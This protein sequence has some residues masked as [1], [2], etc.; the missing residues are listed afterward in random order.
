MSE[1]ILLARSSDDVPN[2]DMIAGAWLAEF[3]SYET[4]KAYKRDLAAWFQFCDV[5][6]VDPVNDAQRSHVALYARHN[7][8]TGLS[9]A[10]RAR[11]I[12]TLR[13]WYGWMQ[14]EHWIDRANPAARIKS[15]HVSVV[16]PGTALSRGQMHQL[17]AHAAEQDNPHA[18]ALVMLG[19]VNGL[20]IAEICG[21]A[22]DDI[23]RERFHHVARVLRKGGAYHVVGLQP[24]VMD[25]VSLAVDDRTAG[26][27]LLNTIG[28]RLR[29]S[30]ARTLL[31]HLCEDAGVTR[32]TP[33]DLRR[34]CAT[35]LLADGVPIADVAKHLNHASVSTTM[36]YDHRRRSL[37]NDLGSRLIQYTA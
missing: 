2:R 27:L 1:T 7:D 19:Y 13:G 18:Y 36:R 21:I 28:D 34:T 6:Q 24:R 37:D 16:R 33:H 25:A 11:R 15:P 31:D 12:G 29:P 8:D 17:M 35:H 22:V 3:G 9:P 10:T 4:R 30:A 26:N 32:I 14:D 5:Y 20:R 23:G